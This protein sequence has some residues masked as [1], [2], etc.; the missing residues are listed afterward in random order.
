MTYCRMNEKFELKLTAV[1]A[2]EKI[3]LTLQKTQNEISR[4]VIDTREQAIREALIRLGWTPP[5]VLCSEGPNEIE[6]M[7]TLYNELL[8]AV[9]CKFEGETRHE[10]AL[11]YIRDRENDRSVEMEK[12]K[13]P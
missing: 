8:F 2:D 6:Q 5:P 7:R 4:W 3:H 11:R 12:S 13:N 1:V 9:V 10:T